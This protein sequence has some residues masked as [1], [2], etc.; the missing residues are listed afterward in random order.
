MKA[1]LLTAV[2][3]FSLLHFSTAQILCIYCYD[4]NDSISNGVNN[5]ILNGS[6]EN[7]NCTPNTNGSSYCP[8]SV[9]YNCTV[10]DWTCTGGGMYTYASMWTNQLTVVPD[11]LVAPYFGNDFCFA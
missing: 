8:S 2:F 7:H 10:A 9:N 4:Q 5:L 6:F 1:L 3:I 11:G